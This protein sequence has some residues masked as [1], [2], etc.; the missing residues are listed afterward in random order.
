[1]QSEDVQENLGSALTRVLRIKS[2]KFV[3]IFLDSED[4]NDMVE[5][6]KTAPVEI[7]LT[8][9]SSWENQFF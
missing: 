8:V 3:Y 6:L 2:S 1:M 4:D 9:G 5:F 7:R